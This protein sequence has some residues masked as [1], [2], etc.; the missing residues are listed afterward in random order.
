MG[1]SSAAEAYV[2]LVTNNQYCHGAIALGQSLR[3]TGTNRKLVVMIT[4]QVYEDMR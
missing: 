4:Q 3:N 1:T 2:S